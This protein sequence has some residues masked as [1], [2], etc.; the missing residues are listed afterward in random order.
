MFVLVNLYARLFQEIHRISILIIYMLEGLKKIIE[1][2][3]W[4]IYMLETF[5]RIHKM[6]GLII[7][8]SDVL[9]KEKYILSV[10]F[11]KFIC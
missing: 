11:A 6:F 10:C 7:Y 3:F 2:L 5:K 8:M 9:K 4:S 1:C